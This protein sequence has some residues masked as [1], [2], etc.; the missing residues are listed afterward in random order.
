[1]EPPSADA[2]R[3]RVSLVA[4]GFSTT[5]GGLYILRDSEDMTTDTE[6]SAIAMAEVV[7]GHTVWW[8]RVATRTHSGVRSAS[9][10]GTCS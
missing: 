3:S 4:N 6:E 8:C 1:M 9:T 7:G 10:G 2:V 5:T